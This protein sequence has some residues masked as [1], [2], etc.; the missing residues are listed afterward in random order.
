MKILTTLLSGSA[1]VFASGASAQTPPE[2]ADGAESYEATSGESVATEQ[3]T[4]EQTA[5]A[6]FSDAEIESF[7]A[8]ALKMQA[9]DA[10]PTTQKEQMTA[11]VADSGLTIETFN[12]IS[13]AMQ[14]DAEVANRVQVAAAELRQSAG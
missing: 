4:S 11:I 5:E 1:L 9:L 12:A 6:T 7:A 3:A 14:T 13:Q 10:D 8:A 2:Q